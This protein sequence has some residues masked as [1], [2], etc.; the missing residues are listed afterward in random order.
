MFQ[1]KFIK[2][3]INS[4]IKVFR[5][6]HAIWINSNNINV[7]LSTRCGSY[8]CLFLVHYDACWVGT[9]QIL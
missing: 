8:K 5:T 7:Y 2:C 3:A 9:D 1:R 6:F 4:L